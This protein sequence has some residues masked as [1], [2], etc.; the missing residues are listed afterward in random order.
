METDNYL[1]LK[2]NFRQLAP[3][4]FEMKARVEE[5]EGGVRT[6]GGAINR[7]VCA[8]YNKINGELILLNQPVPGTLGLKNDLTAGPIFWPSLTTTNQELITWHEAHELISLAEEGKID[9]SLA[10]NLKEND[11]PVIV[12]ATPK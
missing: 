4:P 2:F 12:I 10:A 6:I 1:F 3:E 9:K 5:I 11:N 8:V 7:E